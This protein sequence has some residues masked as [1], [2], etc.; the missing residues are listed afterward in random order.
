MLFTILINE[1]LFK[2]DDYYEKYQRTM[3]SSPLIKNFLLNPVL[4]FADDVLMKFVNRNQA[5][6]IIRLVD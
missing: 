6:Q 1:L 2:M 4:A 5:A 3:E